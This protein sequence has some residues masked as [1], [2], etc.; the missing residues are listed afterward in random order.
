MSFKDSNTSTATQIT[1]TGAMK[2]CIGGKSSFGGCYNT[3][4]NK[5]LINANGHIDNCKGG[6][7]SF[8]GIDSHL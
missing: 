2:D 7:Y 3:G 1:F 4:A 6:D 8:Y 5:V